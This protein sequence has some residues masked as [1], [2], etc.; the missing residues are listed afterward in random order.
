MSSNVQHFK[1]TRERGHAKEAADWARQLEPMLTENEVR[2]ILRMLADEVLNPTPRPS[3]DTF[4]G[5]RRLPPDYG[6]TTHN[7][8]QDEWERQIYFA[9]KSFDGKRE[10]AYHAVG[11]RFS[12]GHKNVE[13]ICGRLKKRFP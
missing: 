9:V 8:S 7:V 3:H 11:A 6:G 5:N 12:T 1:E 4:H 2:Q 13:A 10:D